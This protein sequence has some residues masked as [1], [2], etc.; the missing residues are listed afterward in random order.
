MIMKALDDADDDFILRNQIID[1]IV[2]LPNTWR[3]KTEVVAGM[4]PDV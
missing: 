3:S 4:P 2:K 1:E